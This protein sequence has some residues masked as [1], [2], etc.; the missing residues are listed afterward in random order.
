MKKRVTIV[1]AIIMSLMLISSTFC[2]AE[3]TTESGEKSAI[4]NQVEGA[5]IDSEGNVIFPLEENK[6]VIIELDN[7]ETIEYK[8]ESSNLRSSTKTYRIQKTLSYLPSL[9]TLTLYYNVNCTWGTPSRC[10]T[11]N[12]F[13]ATYNG[14]R[15]E[16]ENFSYRITERVSQPAGYARA[17]CSGKINFANNNQIITSTR[18]FDHEI[19]ADSADSSNVYIKVIA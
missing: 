15:A 10:V 1:T 13:I 16:V 17:R 11:M 5:S 19:Y 2:F 18:T 7:G 12:S 9:S 14:V 8:M 6:P 4:L 3:S